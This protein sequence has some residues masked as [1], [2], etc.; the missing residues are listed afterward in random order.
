MDYSIIRKQPGPG[1]VFMLQ[2]YERARADFNWET[3]RS[4]LS[5]CLQAG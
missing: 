4:L 2:D 3:A 5:G 1:V